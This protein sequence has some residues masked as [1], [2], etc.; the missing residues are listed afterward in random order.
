MATD[1]ENLAAARTALLVA[2]AANA[3]KPNVS[4]DGESISW[5]E[6]FDR[7]GK[8]DA[9]MASIQGPFEHASWGESGNGQ[10]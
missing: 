1:L 7:L 5:G 10:Y 8:I 9:A 6:L 4:L 3:G 2:L